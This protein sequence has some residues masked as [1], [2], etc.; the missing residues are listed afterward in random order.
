MNGR[1]LSRRSLI[2][3]GGQL[4]AA[5]VAAGLVAIADPDQT[6]AACRSRAPLHQG[7]SLGSV[8]A[9]LRAVKNLGQHQFWLDGPNVPVRTSPRSYYVVDLR[10]GANYSWDAHGLVNGRLRI[11]VP[12]SWVVKNLNAFVTHPFVLIYNC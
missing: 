9:L 7:T 6:E 12:T 4:G 1:L 8:G 11:G 10:S 2:V 5:S 3:R